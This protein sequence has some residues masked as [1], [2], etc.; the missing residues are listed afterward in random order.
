MV[1]ESMRLRSGTHNEHVA[2]IDAALKP[3][4]QKHTIDKPAQ[5]QPNGDQAQRDEHDAARNIRGMCQI[6][7]AGQQQS[8]GKARL[9]AQ[10]LFMQVVG[11]TGRIVEVHPPAGEDKR[12]REAAQHRQKNPH[13]TSVEKGS[14]IELAGA[15]YRS[16]VQF[17][18]GGNYGRQDDRQNIKTNPEVGGAM[19]IARRGSRSLDR[20]FRGR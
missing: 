6:E 10:A 5:A 18:C 8:G 4:I 15:V 1:A 3:A 7:R 2:Q 20:P 13:R 14:P 11:Q 9:N 17:E 19:G 16:G 12:D